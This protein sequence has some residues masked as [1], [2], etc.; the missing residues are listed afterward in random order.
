MGD[1][2]TL[3][4]LAIS[5]TITLTCT[6]DHRVIQG[7]GSGEFLK[8][9][10]EL[11]TGKNGFYEDIFA[12]L[13]IPYAPIRWN[14][15]VSVD[16]SQR[17]DKTSR[18]QELIN[19]YRVR[20]HLMADIDPLAYV[21]REHHD[22]EIESHGLSFW[23]LEREFITNGFTG[24]RHAKLRDIL[25]VLRDLYCRTIG[26]EYMHISD[27]EQR[28]LVPGEGRARLRRRPTTTTSCASSA[29]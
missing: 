12:A 6:Y 25:G 28:K 4:K 18:V 10:H 7:A 11:L 13:R 23:D 26:Y 24:K 17:V 1:P 3:N 5:K 22:L 21:Q 19:S 9:V 29:S 16:L 2:R 27:Y 20:G 15:D 14:A 8:I